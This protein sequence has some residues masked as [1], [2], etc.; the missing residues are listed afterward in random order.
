MCL[1]LTLISSES[2]FAYLQDGQISACLHANMSENAG[3]QRLVHIAQ[4]TQLIE[5]RRRAPPG[6]CEVVSNLS[7]LG[8]NKGEKGSSKV[9]N[10]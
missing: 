1:I 9:M 2:H 5:R 4:Y 8:N 3:P 10:P 7:R 6:S